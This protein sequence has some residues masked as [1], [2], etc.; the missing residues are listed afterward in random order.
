[1]L[2]QIH[3]RNCPLTGIEIKN[4]TA[5]RE[6]FKT[7]GIYY[8]LNF[9]GE[10]YYLG[11]C[12]YLYDLLNKDK[13][14]LER[15]SL[16]EDREQLKK[17]LPIFYGELGKKNFKDLF[18]KTVH[19]DCSTP[20][21]DPDKH[22]IIKSFTKEIIE[23]GAFPKTRKE[24]TNSI[25]KAIR[26]AQSYEGEKIQMMDEFKY[27]GKFY[28]TNSLEFKY[29]LKHLEFQGYIQIENPFVSL[30]FNGLDYTE[31]IT[32]DST[33]STKEDMYQI[34]L[35][36]A[37]EERKFVEEVAEHLRN[38]GIKVFY[39]NYEKIDLWG[40]DLYHHLNEVYKSKCEYCI[41]FISENYAKK[42]WTNHELKS[43]QARAF[44]ENRE[45]ILPVRFDETKLPGLNDTVG[46]ISIK[47]ETPISIAELAIKK[48]NN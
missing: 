23:K 28:L 27:W 31:N 39:D 41:I 18:D 20:S 3:L 40:K 33:E 46:Y 15:N 21:K 7:R 14:Y 38:N 29:Y 25:L 44:K 24:K 8:R 26:D 12:D 4:H 2:D 19:W 48:L 10:E 16:L 36:F 37:G 30:T 45:Y 5:H 9:E 35:S 34:G 47:N 43:A 13:D 32:V 11:I 6:Y 17:Y 1:M 42:L 22:I